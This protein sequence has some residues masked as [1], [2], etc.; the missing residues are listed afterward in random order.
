M[1]RSDLLDQRDRGPVSEYLHRLDER[2]VLL[3]L[4]EVDD[5]A[6]HL[7]AEAVVEASRRGHLKTGG[8]LVVEWAQPFERPTTRVAQR[9]VVADDVLDP[10]ALTDGGDVLF[11]D[12]PCHD[13]AV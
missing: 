1:V 4:E 12:P 13:P 2:Q 6:A 11:V 7:A 10:A 8:L 3:A 5:V 9:H